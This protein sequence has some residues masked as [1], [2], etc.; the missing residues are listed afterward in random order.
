[1]RTNPIDASDRSPRISRALVG[2][3]VLVLGACVAVESRGTHKKQ[4]SLAEM[5]EGS[6]VHQGRTRRF[7]IYT[8]S[9]YQNGNPAP[10]VFL[11]HGGGGHNAEKMVSMTGFNEVA[12]R[13]GVIAVYP[14]SAVAKSPEGQ[15]WNDG[16]NSTNTIDDVSFVIALINHLKTIRSIDPRRIYATGASNGGAMTYRLACDAADHFAA[17]A[18]VIINMSENLMRNC[19]PS[20]PVPMMVVNGVDDP[21]MPWKGGTVS[22]GKKVL[23]SIQ[24]TA[25]SVG[26]WVNAN[27]CSNSPLSE[28]LPDRDRRDGTQIEKTTYRGCRDNSEVLLLGV[29]GGGHAWPGSP[30]KVSRRREKLRGKTSRDID[31]SQAI[32][33]FFKKYQLP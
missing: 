15:L 23:G 10:V 12:D 22:F 6:I 1:M 27:G 28:N 21:V 33:D 31:G 7:L 2:V 32:W 8:P 26:F 17:F 4:A 25:D 20:R 13:E 18:P 5:E 24:S 14:S 19:R 30:E 3:L 11:F 16:R 9:S 29:H